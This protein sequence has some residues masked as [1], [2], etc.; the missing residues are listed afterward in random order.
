M[1]AVV[2]KCGRRRQIAGPLPGRPVLSALFGVLDALDLSACGWSKGAAVWRC[3]FCT[4]RANTMR[5]IEGGKNC[6]VTDP[7][8]PSGTNG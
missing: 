5:G 1:E 7:P 6:N 3:H 8:P 4:R 2:C